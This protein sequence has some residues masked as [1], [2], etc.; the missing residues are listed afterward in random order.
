MG[1]TG[2]RSTFCA[3]WQWND[4]EIQQDRDIS[5]M[6]SNNIHIPGPLIWHCQLPPPPRGW[7]LKFK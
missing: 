2:I 5:T 3:A 4:V 6:D 7:E 1:T